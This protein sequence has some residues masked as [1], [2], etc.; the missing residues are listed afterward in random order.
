MF[1]KV[2][3]MVNFIQVI[4]KISSYDLINIKKVRLGEHSPVLNSIFLKNRLEG[5]L[6]V[7]VSFFPLS[8]PAGILITSFGIANEI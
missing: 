1:Y 3:W 5:K 4:P 2:K 8:E 7:A 6:K